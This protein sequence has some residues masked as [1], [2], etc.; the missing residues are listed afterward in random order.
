[1]VQPNTTGGG[2][3]DNDNDPNIATD[4]WCYEPR[5]DINAWLRMVLAAYAQANPARLLASDQRTLLYRGVDN[6]RAVMQGEYVEADHRDTGATAAQLQ[7]RK[8]QR[9]LSEGRCLPDNATLAIRFCNVT[10]VMGMYMQVG[11]RE[12][13][14]PQ[15]RLLDQYGF[16]RRDP[17]RE[18]SRFN[19]MFQS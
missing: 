16:A 6:A 1:M 15:L 7:R 14:L 13:V 11:A 8:R 10:Y 17:D 2:G 18:W 12:L 3:D 9:P 19:I 5:I 4:E